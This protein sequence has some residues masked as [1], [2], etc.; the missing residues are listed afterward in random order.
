MIHGS[1]DVLTDIHENNCLTISQKHLK[2]YESYGNSFLAW[3]INTDELWVHHSE[4]EHFCE[5][6]IV[7]IILQLPHTS[8]THKFKTHTVGMDM[9][10]L[11]F[12]HFIPLVKSR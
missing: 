9:E 10:G 8:F 6:L 11:L 12:V 2:H 7:C 3:I 4:P 5:S 1:W